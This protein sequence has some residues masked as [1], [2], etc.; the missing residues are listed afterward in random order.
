M[1][2][3]TKYFVYDFDAVNQT[4]LHWAAKRNFPELIDLLVEKGANVNAFDI[5]S[6]NL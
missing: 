3:K 5:V 4:A 2:S 1:L 6:H